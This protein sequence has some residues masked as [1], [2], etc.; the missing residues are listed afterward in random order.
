I[1]GH[2]I[3]YEIFLPTDLNLDVTSLANANKD[4]SKKIMGNK[5]EVYTDWEKDF[6]TRD[7]SKYNA[8]GLDSITTFLDLI[9]DY[10]LTVN[11]RP[12][13]WPDQSDYGPQMVTFTNVMRV[14]NSLGITLYCTGHLSYD[15]DDLTKKIYRMPMMTGRLKAKIPLLFSDILGTSHEVDKDNKS[16]Y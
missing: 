4:R 9:M 7:L 2:D 12:G 15:Q 5:S 14:L 10:V 13:Q 1:R 6:S 11:G 16:S 8:V 3:D